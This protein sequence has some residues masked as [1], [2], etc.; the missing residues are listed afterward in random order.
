LN[1]L[2]EWHGGFPG[3]PA[4]VVG[5]TAGDRGRRAGWFGYWLSVT[6]YW[7]SVWRRWS[8]FCSIL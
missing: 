1:N 6:G 4:S 5:N 8:Y 3:A 2:A 7:L